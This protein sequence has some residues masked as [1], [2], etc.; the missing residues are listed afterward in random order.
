[1]SQ[2]TEYREYFNYFVMSHTDSAAA[3]EYSELRVARSGIDAVPHASQIQ[4]QSARSIF[5]IHLMEPS[6]D[7]KLSNKFR[8]AGYLMRL[9]Q[10]MHRFLF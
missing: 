9:L 5:S 3:D 6:R 1:M 8:Y 7:Q 2:L 4:V 10:R